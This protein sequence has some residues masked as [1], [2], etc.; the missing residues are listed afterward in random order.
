MIAILIFNI[1]NFGIFGL[2]YTQFYFNNEF[3]KFEN[4]NL[5]SAFGDNILQF[6]SDRYR[7]FRSIGYLLSDEQLH[8]PR[9]CEAQSEHA[10][11]IAAE[12]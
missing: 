2:Y 4:L 8:E 3:S 1:L 7:L 11:A 12:Q 10:G 9:I 6:G 5:Y